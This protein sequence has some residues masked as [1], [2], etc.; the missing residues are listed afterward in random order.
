MLEHRTAKTGDLNAP[1]WP[2]SDDGVAFVAL[3]EVYDILAMAEVS[4][5]W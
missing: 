3:C 5:K 1:S 2:Q 4:T